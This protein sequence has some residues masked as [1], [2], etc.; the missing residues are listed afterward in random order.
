MK[1]IADVQTVPLAPITLVYG[2]NSA[3]KSTL[4]QALLLMKQTMESADPQDPSLVLRGPLVDLGSFSSLAHRHDLS[5]PVVLGLSF[6]AVAA[7]SQRR[8][9]AY[10]RMPLQDERSVS[11]LFKADDPL[12]MVEQPLATVKLGALP[13]VNFVR[14]SSEPGDDLGLEGEVNPS[15]FTLQP[16][17]ASAFVKMLISF[18]EER[19]RQQGKPVREGGRPGGGVESAE[20]LE[21]RVSFARFFARTLLPG[22]LSEIREPGPPLPPDEAALAGADRAFTPWEAISRVLRNEFEMLL[23]R[24]SYLG[25]IRHA[26]QRFHIFSGASRPN[27]G[28]EG[29]H[30]VELMARNQDLLP[31]LNRWLSALKIPYQLHVSRLDAPGDGAALGD[32][33]SLVLTDSRSGVR[34][35]PNDVGF[36]LSQLLPIL[37]QSLLTQDSL[38]CVEQPEIHLHPILQ[39]ELGDLLIEAAEPPLQNQFLI[40]T[41]SEHLMLRIQKRVRQGRL[42]PSSV[43][44]LF[45]EPLAN[46]NA[47]IIRLR[48]DEQG[49]FLDEWPA[50]FFE[51][52]FAE[53]FRG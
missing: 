13:P 8:R 4:L 52:R 44:V 3:G 43:A 40:E 32:I 15:Y 49:D 47:S 12:G 36:G 7:T 23:N 25:P 5:S 24:T 42:D 21:K 37:V 19:A 14:H 26:P 28:S 18:Q 50:G 1:S 30:T 16:D 48:L 27:V 45:V 6:D 38:I 35:A 20:E 51:E 29:E 10:L 9:S 2:P 17:S 41:H 11:F 46:G 31:D 22:A 39:A 33:V 53:L 34:V